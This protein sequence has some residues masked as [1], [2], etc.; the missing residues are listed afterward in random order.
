MTTVEFSLTDMSPY[1]EVCWFFDRAAERLNISQESRE[2]L[3]HPW[4][5][6]KVE[7]PVRMEDGSLKVFI[8]YRV[9]HNGARGPYKGGVRYHPKA[10]L[11][12]VRALAALMTWKTAV[13]EIPYGGAKGGIQCDPKELSETELNRLT[14][15]YTQNISYIIG[16]N[17]DIPAPDLGT[18]AQVMAWMMDAY[19]QLHG[20]SPGIVTGKPIELGGSYGREAATGRGAV[21][22]LETYAGLSDF[23]LKGATAVV[24]GFGNVG[25]CFARLVEGLGCKV[26][27]IS[28]SKGAVY[29]P[30]G[31]N[32][33]DLMAHK[34]KTGTV[35]GFSGA[36]NITNEELLAL[37][38]DVL[39]PAAME[40]VLNRENAHRVQA[41]LVVE[42][43]N[44]PT[45]P[46]ADMVLSQKGTPV[47][48]DILANAGGVVVSYFEWAQNIQRFRW[49][50]KRVNQELRT[51]MVRATK[52]VC[53]EAQR[54]N[55]TLR[56][57]AFD[58][59]VGRV[60]QAIDLRGFV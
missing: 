8:G 25:S 3:R 42:C 32:L 26:S 58:I 24:Q 14:R 54:Q 15:R 10:D 57:A 27:S 59:G 35:V 33:L 43:A 11:D 53:Q 6:L 37:P 12:E 20:Y 48:P 7:V 51:I 60:A 5:E 16:V 52:Q 31:L 50:E 44:H 47:L 49:E 9:Q 4:R 18:N 21:N 13:T 46:A 45:T 29:N 23:N 55:I 2:L 19:G 36:E 30:Q 28:D 17:R 22:V 41:R 56:E 38:C 34:Q 40:S 39:A 1:E